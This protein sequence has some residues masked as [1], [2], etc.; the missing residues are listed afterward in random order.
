[1]CHT[2]CVL[3][4]CVLGWHVVSVGFACATTG[5]RLRCVC[6]TKHTCPSQDDTKLRAQHSP[7]S[8]LWPHVSH[9]FRGWWCC[10]CRQV[11]ASMVTDLVGSRCDEV[12]AC[13]YIRSDWPHKDPN[14]LCMEATLLV[15]EDP[16]AAEEKEGEAASTHC[17]CTRAPSRPGLP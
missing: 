7:H 13:A 11:A 16:A 10:C 3:C 1:M 8:D 17:V 15:V 5:S 14:E 4:V 9:A 12:V 2:L 6:C